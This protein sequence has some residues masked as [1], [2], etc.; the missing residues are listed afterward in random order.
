MPLS[1]KRV[2]LSYS[3]FDTIRKVRSAYANVWAAFHHD[4]GRNLNIGYEAR[5]RLVIS[6]CPSNSEWFQKFSLLCKKR[7]GQDSRQ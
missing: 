4:A 7:M 6:T 3:Q 5:W 1:E 2:I